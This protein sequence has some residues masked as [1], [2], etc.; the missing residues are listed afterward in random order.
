MQGTRPFSYSYPS[1][2]MQ[3]NLHSQELPDGQS[4]PLGESLGGELPLY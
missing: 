4:N 3:V 2:A 1:R